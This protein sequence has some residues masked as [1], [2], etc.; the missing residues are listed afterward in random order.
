M[1]EKLN[2]IYNQ[3]VERTKEKIIE[4][5]ERFMEWHEQKPSLTEYLQK[6]NQ[7]IQHIW[8]NIWSNKA[9]SAFSVK[10]RKNYL[11]EKGI[12]FDETNKKLI[13]KLFINTIIKHH[14]FPVRIWIKQN[15]TEELWNHIVRRN[16]TK[17]S[18]VN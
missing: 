17:A 13:K 16:K 9:Q 14:P 3:A 11:I 5:I 15:I 4:D 18:N 2:A 10:E 1:I 6:R 12:A 8:N 7:F